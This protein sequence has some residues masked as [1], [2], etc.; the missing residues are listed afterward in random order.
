MAV[1]SAEAIS[2]QSLGPLGI[3][4]L[5]LVLKATTVGSAM[6]MIDSV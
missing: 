5:V 2:N 6:A 3:K 4:G 1:S